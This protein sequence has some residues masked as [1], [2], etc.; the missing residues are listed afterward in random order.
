MVFWMAGRA[1]GTDLL[2]LM[3]FSKITEHVYV[4]FLVPT[5]TKELRFYSSWDSSVFLLNKLMRMVWCLVTRLRKIS[6][7]LSSHT[8]FDA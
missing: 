6:L 5:G 2:L 8:H 4:F 3:S 7:L 1:A